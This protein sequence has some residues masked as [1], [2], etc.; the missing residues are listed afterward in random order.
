[1]LLNCHQVTQG[2]GYLIIIVASNNSSNETLD[3]FSAV[4]GVVDDPGA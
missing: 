4:I 1:M 3:C 2:P